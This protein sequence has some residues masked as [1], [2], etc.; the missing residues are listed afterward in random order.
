MARK[1]LSVALPPWHAAFLR[2]LGKLVAPSA[3]KLRHIRL[4]V[5]A[6]AQPPLRVYHP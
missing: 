4:E 1:Y 3:K 2:V 6:S 5:Q